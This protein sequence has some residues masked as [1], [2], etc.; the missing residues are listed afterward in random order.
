MELRFVIK[1]APFITNFAYPAR[2]LRYTII[3]ICLGMKFLFHNHEPI[4]VIK[5]KGPALCATIVANTLLFFILFVQFSQ[6]FKT[7]C[8]TVSKERNI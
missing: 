2:H 7:N 5:Y 3:L 8:N 4:V 6:F 1:R